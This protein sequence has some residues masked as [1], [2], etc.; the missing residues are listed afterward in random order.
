MQSVRAM[1]LGM[2]IFGLGVSPLAVVQES[3]IVRFF[4]GHGLGLSMAFGLVVGKASSF[5]S[6]RTSYQLSERFGQRAPFY[7]ATSLA[8]MSFLMNLVYLAASRWLIKSSG[9][10]LE[11]SE[12]RQEARL[13]EGQNITEAQAMRKVAQKKTVHMDD[14]M[15]LGD[16]FWA[17]VSCTFHALNTF[18][19][20]TLQLYLRQHFMW[21]SLEPISSPCCVRYFLRFYPIFLIIHGRNIIQYRYD[22][23]ESDASLRASYLLA[24]SVFLYPIVSVPDFLIIS[25]HLLSAVWFRYRSLA[26]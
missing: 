23:A 8:A 9:T 2:F 16:V 17:S 24:A 25:A 15:K 21:R 18:V 13:L 6:A 22:L 26:D 14:M 4:T 10:E 12:L 1:T 11:A 7:A 3:I 20:I 5:I 19:I